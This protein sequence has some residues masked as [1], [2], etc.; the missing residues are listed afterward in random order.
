MSE[1]VASSQI[2]IATLDP[3]LAV[4]KVLEEADFAKELEPRKV[5]G[6]GG[7]DS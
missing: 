4:V 6:V 2:L 5:E 1:V 7:S 3:P